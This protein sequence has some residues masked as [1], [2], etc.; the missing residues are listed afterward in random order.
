[1]PPGPENPFHIGFKYT[2]TEL[3]SELGAIRDV[4]SAKSRVWKIRNPNV[5]NPRTG[6][7]LYLVLRGGEHIPNVHRLMHHVYCSWL[8]MRWYKTLERT[9]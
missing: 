7:S 3:T 2:E 5:K 6:A 4:D 8:Y 1:M 9:P